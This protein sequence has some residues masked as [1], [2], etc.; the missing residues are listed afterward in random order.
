VAALEATLCSH[1]WSYQNIWVDTSAAS[2]A[3]FR[4]VGLDPYFA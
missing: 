4:A 3:S 2:L 1:N